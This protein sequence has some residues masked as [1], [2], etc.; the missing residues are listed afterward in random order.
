MNQIGRAEHSQGLDEGHE[1]CIN[2]GV[3]AAMTSFT[4][5]ALSKIDNYIPNK[6]QFR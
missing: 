5:S 1:S 3:K 4:G 6:S 2:K